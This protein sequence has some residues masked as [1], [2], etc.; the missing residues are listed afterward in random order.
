MDPDV[1]VD[2]DPQNLVNPDLDPDPGRI[3]VN[4]ITKVSKHLLNFKS[5]KNF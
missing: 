3:Q 2:P 4:K 5:Q 1:D